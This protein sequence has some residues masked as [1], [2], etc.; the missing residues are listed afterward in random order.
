MMKQRPLNDVRILDLTRTSAGPYYTMML[1]NMGAD[2]I[3]VEMPKTGDDL[4]YYGPLFLAGESPYFMILNRN[5][6][7]ITLNLKLEQGKQFFRK[8]IPHVNVLV[9][10]FS[11]GTM[12]ELGLN[13]ENLRFI[14]PQL[15]YCSISGFGSKGPDASRKEYDL[16][17]QRMGIIMRVTG[18]KVGGRTL[19]L[20]VA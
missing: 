6:R 15:I 3:K 16:I 8:M 17:A 4:S 11:L 10:N 9:D 1:G 18:K 12:E 20:G 14:N 7:S 19:K 2:V 5:K 13:Y